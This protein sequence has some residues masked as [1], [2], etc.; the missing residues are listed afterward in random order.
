MHT[1]LIVALGLCMAG[2][3][4]VLIAGMVGLVR[5]GDNPARSNMLMRWRVILQFAAI[6][7]FGLLITLLKG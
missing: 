2:V 4:G 6:L 3:L 7:L 5:G 1:F